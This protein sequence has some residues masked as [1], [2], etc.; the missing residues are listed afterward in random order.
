MEGIVRHQLAKAGNIDNTV[1]DSA[2]TGGWHAGDAPDKR[3]IAVARQYGIDISGQRARQI[4]SAD[5]SQFDWILC[6]DQ[7]NL[8][9]LQ[10][11]APANATARATLFLPWCGIDDHSE[12]PDPYY[13]GPQAFEFVYGLIDRATR[14][15][16][17]SAFFEKNTRPDR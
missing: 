1:F 11:R 15:W 4:T 7:Q 16:I 3:S 8:S 14:H 17:N 9:E 2:G 10:R 5:F 13:D 6:A 12:I